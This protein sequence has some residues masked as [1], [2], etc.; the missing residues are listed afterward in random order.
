M[1]SFAIEV[2]GGKSVKLPTAGKY[3][4]RDIVVT[5][6]GSNDAFWEEFQQGG[7]RSN[8]SNAFRIGWTNSIFK[9]KYDIAGSGS[10]AS[11]FAATDIFG[12][13]AILLEGLGRKLDTSRATS[14][15]SLFYN[16]AKLTRV[17]VIDASGASDITYMFDSA[18]ALQ[19]IDK[20][21]LK[22]NGSQSMNAFRNLTALENLTIEGVIGQNGLD[23]HWSTKLSKASLIS[24]VNALST[25]TTGLAVTLSKTAVNTAFETEAAAANGTESQQ[26]LALIATRGNWTIS[27]I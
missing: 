23:I 27:L 12:D 5:A 1:S 20:V 26:W 13:L 11:A 19:T 3:C 22:S 14:L 25:T 16:A 7:N 21:I 10:F 2:E 4:D 17:P 8:Y 24:I 6:T 15:N 9:P 18:T